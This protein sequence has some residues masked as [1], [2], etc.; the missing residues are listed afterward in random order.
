MITTF[1]NLIVICKKS[2]TIKL[3]RQTVSIFE[4][5]ELYHCVYIENEYRVYGLE[6]IY[7]ANKLEF[8]KNFKIVKAHKGGNTL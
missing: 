7:H 2:I 5:N 6:F 1:E 8:F 3:A 4:K